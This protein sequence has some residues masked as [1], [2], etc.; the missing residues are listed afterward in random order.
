[1]EVRLLLQ[2]RTICRAD[3]ESFPWCWRKCSRILTIDLRFVPKLDNDLSLSK[4]RYGKR[5]TNMFIH[6]LLNNR[7]KS[8]LL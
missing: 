1:M 4:Q 8:K 3:V 2:F 5:I 6:H 7:F